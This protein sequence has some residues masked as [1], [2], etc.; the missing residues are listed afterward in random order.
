MLS[1]DGPVTS[2]AAELLMTANTVFENARVVGVPSTGMPVSKLASAMGWLK[3]EI[4]NVVRVRCPVKAKFGF[5]GSRFSVVFPAASRILS[6]ISKLN[7]I[8]AGAAV[9]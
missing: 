1:D 3:L 7:R 8:A 6:E 5:P 9:T 2:A 4:L